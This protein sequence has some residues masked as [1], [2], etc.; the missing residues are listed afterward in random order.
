[1]LHLSPYFVIHNFAHFRAKSA[2]HSLNVSPE[3]LLQ[4]V[5]VGTD[6]E[7]ASRLYLK[8]VLT[9]KRAVDLPMRTAG[10]FGGWNRWSER[11][12]KTRPLP[13]NPRE[14]RRFSHTWKSHRRDRT[15]WLT[16]QS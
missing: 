3:L 10:S 4:H 13:A 14:C 9:V 8:R 5:P 2:F 15:G 7:S 11:S 6:S 1:M 12:P 16:T